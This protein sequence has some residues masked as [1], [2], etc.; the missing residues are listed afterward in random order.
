[1]RWHELPLLAILRRPFRCL[2]CGLRF[3]GQ[4]RVVDIP[5]WFERSA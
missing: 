1:V 2:T 4:M 3:F 5:Q